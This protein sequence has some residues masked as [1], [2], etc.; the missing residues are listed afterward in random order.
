MINFNNF[1]RFFEAV[2]HCFKGHVGSGILALPAAFS[3]AGL[4][5]GPI[6][7][8]IMSAICARTMIIL[9]VC[10]HKLGPETGIAKF[11][12]PLLVEKAIERNKA[13]KSFSKVGRFVA[14]S[15]NVKYFKQKSFKKT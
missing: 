10:A 4:I 2:I 13:V 5:V 11:T 15:T 14:S 12:Y 7:M 8:I 1:F 6:G 3:N 9:V